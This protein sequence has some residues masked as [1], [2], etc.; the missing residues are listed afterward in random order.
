MPAATR[1]LL[2]A[3]GSLALVAGALAA[4]LARRERIASACAGA[5]DRIA[6]LA[7]RNGA[8]DA[9]EE[10]SLAS[11]PASDPPS[12]GGASL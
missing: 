7:S 11:F 1:R 3:A 6:A 5:R 9:V 10:A 8:V 12:W 4:A 2:I